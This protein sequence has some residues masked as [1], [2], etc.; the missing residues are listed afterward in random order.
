M[1]Q[2]STNQ[3][4]SSVYNRPVAPLGLLFLWPG[5]NRSQEHNSCL[6]SAVV[7]HHHVENLL[8]CLYSAQISIVT[9]NNKHVHLEPCTL[10]WI[11]R[12]LLL[13]QL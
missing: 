2:M 7:L 4:T 13:W 3:L 11:H 5:L 9:V 6:D 8:H 1:L 10:L 12:T